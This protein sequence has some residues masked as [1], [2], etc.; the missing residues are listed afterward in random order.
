MQPDGMNKLSKQIE[1]DVQNYKK[2]CASLL[3]QFFSSEFLFYSD[4][5]KKAQA[6]V[7]ESFPE[8]LL[9]KDVQSDEAQA[10]SFQKVQRFLDLQFQK[11]GSLLEQGKE[12]EKKLKEIKDFQDRFILSLGQF[13]WCLDVRPHLN[14]LVEDLKKLNVQKIE[15]VKLETEQIESVIDAAY[16]RFST[17]KDG[18]GALFDAIIQECKQSE[19]SARDS[20]RTTKR[21]LFEIFTFVTP[22]PN[23]KAELKI[24]ANNL[25]KK[26]RVWNSNFFQGQLSSEQVLLHVVELPYEHDVIL[27]RNELD[28]RATRLLELREETHRLLRHMLDTWHFLEIA[29]LSLQDHLYR[30]AS[31]LISDLQKYLELV[32]NP[33]QVFS[34]SSEFENVNETFRRIW[35]QLEVLQPKVQ[36][37]QKNADAYLHAHFEKIKRQFLKTVDDLEEVCQASTGVRPHLML[38]LERELNETLP[39]KRLEVLRGQMAMLEARYGFARPF[40]FFMSIQDFRVQ[41]D[42]LQQAEHLFQRIEATILFAKSLQYMK[43]FEEERVDVILEGFERRFLIEDSKIRLPQSAWDKYLKRMEHTILLIEREVLLDIGFLDMRALFDIEEKQLLSMLHLAIEKAKAH[44]PLLQEE[45]RA[46]SK[47]K[48]EEGVLEKRVRDALQQ[49]LLSW[50]ESVLES[51]KKSPSESSRFWLKKLMLF[52]HILFEAKILCSAALGSASALYAELLSKLSAY[53]DYVESYLVQKRQLKGSDKP[54]IN[55]CL[56]L[57]M[58]VINLELSEENA[59]EFLLG[60]ESIFKKIEQIAEIK[61]QDGQDNSEKD[62]S[63]RAGLEK[64]LRDHLE[65]LSHLKR[66]AH[67]EKPLHYVPGYI[68]YFSLG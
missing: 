14:A 10:A 52:C 19:R 3:Q 60:I 58:H 38:P 44:V 47:E 41:Q 43:T 65:M 5:Q 48:K 40:S 16:A 6:V 56:P 15:F 62:N 35:M 30:D 9:A 20:L 22:Y 61:A 32:E 59:E 7:S 55:E 27:A 63:E 57:R 64:E 68:D 13:K 66:E 50:K 12:R 46:L 33:F 54:W 53:V 21:R 39:D 18:Q 23:L 1:N 42:L 34:T 11:L 25:F 17:M 26:M 28:F 36:A 2:K 49:A 51:E 29:G 67:L 8:E 4:L 45:L 37:C 31:V 24:L